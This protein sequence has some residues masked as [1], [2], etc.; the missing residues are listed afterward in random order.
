MWRYSLILCACLCSLSFV[1]SGQNPNLPF[2]ELR[3]GE[4][5]SYDEISVGGGNVT[6]VKGGV[7]TQHPILDCKYAVIGK[8][9]GGKLSIKKQVMFADASLARNMGGEG[10]VKPGDVEYTVVVKSGDNMIVYRA[11]FGAVKTDQQAYMYVKDGKVSKIEIQEWRDDA[12][13]QEFVD[14]FGI[15]PGVKAEWRSFKSSGKASRQTKY[16]FFMGSLE[17]QYLSECIN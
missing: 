3:S 14:T 12:L 1:A 13:M 2:V 10:D 7:E 16:T 6:G 5:I 9:K 8:M 11:M 4:K 15:C 17:K